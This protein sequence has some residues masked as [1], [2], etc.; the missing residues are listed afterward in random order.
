[1]DLYNIPGDNGKD[2]RLQK[3]VEYQ[4]EVPSIH[5]R[6]LGE[7]IKKYVKNKNR[8]VMMCW[9]MSCTYNEV[10]CVLLD[11]LI[12]LKHCNSDNIEEYFESFWEEYKPALDFGSSRKYAKSMDWFPTLMC[13]F[14]RK[15]H[16]HPYKW[17]KSFQDGEYG[18]T[19]LFKS[20]GGMK[21]VGRFAADLF[22]E[23]VLYLNDYFGTTF[24]EP[25]KLDW[26]RCSNLTSGL[27]NIFYMDEEANLFD[28]TGKL[29]CS[30]EI[31]NNK[32]KCVQSAIFC[33]YPEQ[34]GDGIN[35]FIG[36]ICSF[37]NLFKNSRYGG[38]HHDRELGVLRA[39]ENLLPEYND[40]WERLFDLRKSM[41]DP[42]FLGELNDWDG[43]RKERKKMFLTTGKT[44]VEVDKR[45]LVNIRGCNGAGKST[46]PM[47]MLD[48]PKMFIVSKPYQG[49][50]K[51]VLTVFPTYG[52][53]ALGTYKT[54]TGGLDKFPNN[55]LTQKVLWYALKKFPEYDIL[56]EGVIASTVRST[57]VNLFH[58]VERKYPERTVMILNLITPLD[59][60]LQRIQLRNGGKSIKEE[61]VANKHKIVL[62]N[63]EKFKDE[64]FLSL[65]ID[66]S[67][68]PKDKVLKKFLKIVDKYRGE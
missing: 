61:A 51:E 32:L 4:H 15:T 48:D 38:F 53:V 49:K 9:Y 10:T 52:W 62:R 37:R 16:K 20:L 40:L 26:K 25:S 12:D 5:Y 1:M 11:R 18:Y 22:M 13:E 17:L 19:S 31:L 50:E 60:C 28:K 56:M 57:Y 36:K 54:K 46:I 34:R 35:L 29:P 59:V 63:I 30:E 64:G 6:V 14:I 7:Y 41:F 42:R 8:A 65:G 66:P 58:E 68:T 45:L 44:G 23:S 24:V 55:E 33:E 39:Y 2:W 43:I 47:S 67:N 27:L 3:F 21:F